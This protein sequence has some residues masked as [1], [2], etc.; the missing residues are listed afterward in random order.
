MYVPGDHGDQKRA[1][2]ALE[3]ELMMIIII[4]TMLGTE[5]GFST[6]ASRPLKPP[7]ISLPPTFNS[8]TNKNCAQGRHL[9]IFLYLKIIIKKWREA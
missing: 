5:P 8:H 1:R 2:D 7:A 9:L 4:H 3:L 6:R